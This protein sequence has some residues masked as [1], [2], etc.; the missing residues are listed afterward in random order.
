MALEKDWVHSNR[1]GFVRVDSRWVPTP[2]QRFLGNLRQGQQI[3][4]E[5]QVA[6]T[7]ESDPQNLEDYHVAT[8]GKTLNGLFF[9]PFGY[10]QWAH[11]PRGLEHSWT[12]LRGGSKLANVPAPATVVT[13]GDKPSDTS[14]FEYPRYGTG[15][16]WQSVSDT[17]PASR[18]RYNAT[19]SAIDLVNRKVTLSTGE[20]I[21][22][23]RCI[24]SLPLNR[25]IDLA[26]VESPNTA[27][28]QS[29]AGDLKHSSTTI[30][31]LGFN[32]SLPEVLHGRTWIYGADPDVLF[33]RATIVTNFSQSMSGEGRW[34][35]MFET[36]SSAERPIT[37][38]TQELAQ[39]H[40]AELRRWGAIGEDEQPLSI[41][42]RHLE[43]G[44]ACEL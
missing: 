36:S 16:L 28:P 37:T 35:V 9:E 38:D 12:S 14:T 7:K 18:Q 25:A 41:W 5:I 40:L 17:L 4:D 6:A 8:F 30:V 44:C 23:T 19:V 29:L 15:C 11:R 39:L 43:L 21:S 20:V 27:I 26:N 1:G 42:S 2:I 3:C 31:G 33:H 24:S 32:G 13:S 10:K 34:S 22:Y